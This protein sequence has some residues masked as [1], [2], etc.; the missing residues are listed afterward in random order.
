M[1]EENRKD[2]IFGRQRKKENET[3]TEGK[4]R[5]TLIITNSLAQ[6]G[7]LEV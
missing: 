5:D 4:I 2:F 7:T 3:G 1:R 6:K